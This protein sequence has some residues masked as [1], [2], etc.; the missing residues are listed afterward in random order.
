MRTPS[1]PRLQALL[2]TRRMIANPLEVL[3]DHSHR[4]GETYFYH[5]GGVRKVFVTSDPTVLKHVLK[6]NWENYRKSEIQT[7]RMEEFL[8]SGLLTS[9]GD[10]WR[11]QRRLIQQGFRVSALDALAP[12][13]HESL[14]ESLP[15]MDSMVAAGPVRLSA[16]MMALTFTMVAR[17]LFRARLTDAEIKTISHAITTIQAF[18]VRRIVQPYLAPWFVVSGEQRRHQRMREV[19]D[20]ILLRHIRRRRAMP[21]DGSDLLQVLLDAR[22]DESGRGM[23]DE[24]VLQE[25][26]QLL[27]AGHETSSNAL[28]WALYLLCRHPDYLERAREEF[29]RVLG[30]APLSYS[31]VPLLKLNRAILDES[32]RL[33]PPFWMVDR[34]AIGDDEVAGTSIPSGTTVIAFLYAAHHCPR[35]WQHPE[36]FHPERFFEAGPL[37]HGFTYL[38]FGGGPRGCIGAN[39]AMLQMLM[40]MSVVVRRYHIRL[41]EEAPAEIQPMFI[42]RP[43]G[44]IGAVVRRQT[45]TEPAHV[46]AS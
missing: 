42:L 2:D 13:M 16:E 29:D 19:G 22:Y 31:H 39:Y 4:Y 5:F 44:G 21:V 32:L 9:H 10:Y 34:V 28:T 26:M 1:V 8:G 14:R 41:T 20:S 24:Q 33:Y 6:D 15:R 18:M 23:S 35:H 7:E 12:A 37:S 40:V 46:S 38:P 45:K 3:L 25:S 17:S 30:D 11:T 43:A 36:L 27:V